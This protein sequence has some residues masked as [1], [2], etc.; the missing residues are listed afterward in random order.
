VGIHVDEIHTDVV[1]AAG[2]VDQ[3]AQSH[4]PTR[5]GAADEAWANSFRTAAA[6]ARRTA[7]EGFDD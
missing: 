1:P 4:G 3:P 6:L 7:A 2:V 5:L